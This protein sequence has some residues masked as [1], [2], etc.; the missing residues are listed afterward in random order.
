MKRISIFAPALIGLAAWIVAI[1]V[2]ATTVSECQQ[3]ITTVDL[4]G[5]IIGG[6]NPE[7]TRAS[8]NS[9]LSGASAKLDQ[10]K[11][12]DAINKLRDFKSSVLALATPNAKGETKME[13]LDA[14]RLADEADDAIS[15]ITQL[16]PPGTSCP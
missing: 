2:T 11:F 12:C 3:L 13:P 7:R 8:L 1:P 14:N 9:K 16:L 5:V 6:N 10:A 4:A 15:C